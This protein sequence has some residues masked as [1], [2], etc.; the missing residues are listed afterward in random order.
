MAKTTLLMHEFITHD[1]RRFIFSRPD[2]LRWKPGQGVELALLNGHDKGEGHPFTPVSREDDRVLEFLIKRYA[3]DGMTCQLH[4][5]EPGSELDVSEAFGTISYKGPGTFI[6]AGTGI[7]PFLAILR[8]LEH[9][10]ELAGQALI[11]SNKAPRDLIC[12]K[13]LEH[14]LGDRAVFTYTRKHKLSQQGN[15]IDAAFLRGHIE[16]L[17]QTFYVCGPDGFV[18]SINDDLITL[19]VHPDR[20]VYEQ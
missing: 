20:L 9:R 19:G 4:A 2:G 17:D 6:A 16:N 1:T 14:L 5:L 3:D 12:G 15:R 18:S 7:T 11:C 13:E 10:D 8:Q